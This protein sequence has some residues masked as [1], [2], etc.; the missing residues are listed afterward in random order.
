MNYVNTCKTE[1][2]FNTEG[3]NINIM[4]YVYKINKY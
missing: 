4:N 1:Y 2:I 3:L